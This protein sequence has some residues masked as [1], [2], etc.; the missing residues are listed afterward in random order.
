[1]DT[2]WPWYLSGE[3]LFQLDAGRWFSYEPVIRRNRLSTFYSQRKVCTPPASM[4]RATIY[5]KGDRIICTGAA[6]ILNTVPPRPANFREALLADKATVW[7][8]DSLHTQNEAGL[9]TALRE[10]TAMAISDGSY[11]DTYGTA[12]WM[13]GDPDTVSFISGKSICPGAACDHDAYRSELAGIHSIIAVMKKFCE[14][15]D[16]LDGSI[17][18]GCNGM[19]ALELVFDKGTQL[20]KDVPSFDLVAAILRLKKE[21]LL[22][23]TPRFVK[24]HQDE[25]TN[26]L[27]LWAEQN[28]L[29][30]SWA[31][32]HLPDARRRPRH[33]LVKGEP[34][35]L[36]I[37][38][39]K[40]TSAIS[41]QL[42]SVVQNKDGLKYWHTKPDISQEVTDLVDWDAIGRS[43]KGVPRGRRVFVTKHT[44]GMCG[45]RKFMLRWKQW[46]TDQCGTFPMQMGY[47]SHNST[48]D[49]DVSERMAI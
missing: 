46:E 16:I 19:C 32:Q 37:D 29:M 47:G 3:D 11:K 38:D 20:F 36:W 5:L 33:S 35:Q 45:V 42:Y 30:D 7:C 34:W 15:Y 17:E 27:D 23:W 39:R 8:L 14:Y 31:K 28:I 24:G 12:A 41:Q 9:L 2:N 21:S 22:A 13:I 26:D 48:R 40:V 18:L 44:A 6:R 43:M 25:D 10:G 49:Y 1:M 4:Q